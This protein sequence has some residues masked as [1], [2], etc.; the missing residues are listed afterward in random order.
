[1]NL[2]NVESVWRELRD[3]KPRG[4]PSRRSL[5]RFD[6]ARDAFRERVVAASLLASCTE[7][8]RGALE[9][10]LRHTERALAAAAPSLQPALR[11]RIEAL[12]VA[13]AEQLTFEAKE[14]LTRDPWRAFVRARRAAQLDK[15]DA[16]VRFANAIHTS[17]PTHIAKISARRDGDSL[18]V[19]VQ[20]GDKDGLVSAPGIVE[21]SLDGIPHSFEV[22]PDDYELRE[23]KVGGETFGWER[24]WTSPSLSWPAHERAS[25][26]V[27]YSD[28]H[29]PTLTDRI[30]LAD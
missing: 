22:E 18:V 2:E 11:S 12:R 14:W 27:S 13:A 20:L 7:E 25:V 16:R 29:R 30:A 26:V 15:T 1:V 10:A 9:A 21:V 19:S 17:S 23:V 6:R 4:E 3:V 28:G 8:Q 5:A 24:T